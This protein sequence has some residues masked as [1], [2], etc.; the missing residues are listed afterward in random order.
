MPATWTAAGFTATV[1]HSG[2][3]MYDMLQCSVRTKCVYVLHISLTTNSCYVSKQSSRFGVCNVE[4]KCLLRDSKC[5]LVY[6]LHPLD[7][8]MYNSQCYVVGSK[9][10]RPDIQKPRQMENAVRD[11]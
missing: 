4:G 9:S 7:F 1:K 5:I 3:N 11:I 6:Y 2:N 10:F 8:T